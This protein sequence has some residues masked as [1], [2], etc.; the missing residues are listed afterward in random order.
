[1]S[2]KQCR[3]CGKTKAIT[4]FN[5]K[6]KEEQKRNSQCKLCTRKAVM[7]AYY[8]NRDYYLRYRARRNKELRLIASRFLYKYLANQHCIDCGISDPVVLHFD[9]VRG[10]KKMPVSNMV[11][12]SHTLKAIKMEIKKCAIRCANCHARKTAKDRGYYA[13]SL[14]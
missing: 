1:M 2:K 10:K 5:Y 13:H 12:H 6:H 8:K 7:D 9:H 3:K 14:S 11:Q 4:L